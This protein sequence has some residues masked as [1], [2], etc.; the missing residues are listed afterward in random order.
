M[1]EEPRSQE[2]EKDEQPLLPVLAQPDEQHWWELQ[3]GVAV[4]DRLY[5]EAVTGP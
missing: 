4:P 1:V 3:L 5:T 2:T